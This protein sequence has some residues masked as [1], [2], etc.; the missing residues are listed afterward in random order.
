MIAQRGSY[1]VQQLG[2]DFGHPIH[3]FIDAEQPPLAM[4]MLFTRTNYSFFGSVAAGDTCSGPCL[5]A[6][7]LD[8]QFVRMQPVNGGYVQEEGTSWSAMLPMA[9]HSPLIHRHY[10]AHGR[11]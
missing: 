10:H 1:F 3:L 11:L 7:L 9:N 2:V 6:Y 5:T 4:G 8:G